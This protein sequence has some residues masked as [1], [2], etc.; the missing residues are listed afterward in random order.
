MTL[1]ELQKQALQLPISDRWR[2]VQLLLASIQQ[3]TSISPSSTEKE[4]SLMDLD[5]WTQSLIGV[6][7]LDTADTTESYVDYLEEK[8]R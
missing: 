1:P 7:T 4:K 5:P 2:L 8:Y 3:E 6:I